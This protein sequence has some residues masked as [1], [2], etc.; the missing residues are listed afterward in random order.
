MK[1]S[2]EN[3]EL[4]IRIP[5]KQDSFDAADTLIGRVPNVIGVIAGQEYTLS[6][7]IDLGYKG[8]QQ[9]GS[10]IIYFDNKEEF[11]KVCKDNDID[12]WQHDLCA[13][14]HEVIRGSCTVGNKGSM[15][16]SCQLI[17]VK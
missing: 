8:D 16:H 2:K 17:G 13:Y 11:D 6:H 5:L 3:Q 15:C 14:C 12:I 9:E 4:V 7:L 10:P 1:I